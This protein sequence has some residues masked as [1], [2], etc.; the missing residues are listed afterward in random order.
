MTDFTSVAAGNW[1]TPATWD[2]GSGYPDGLDDKA[3]I[4]GYA[5][6]IAAGD[7]DIAGEVDIISGQLTVGSGSSLE[8]GNSVTP[9]LSVDGSSTLVRYGRIKGQDSGALSRIQFATGATDSVPAS[10]HTLRRIL[11]VTVPDMDASD[12]L[13]ATTEADQ[14]T[15]QLEA[16]DGGTLSIDEDIATGGLIAE[17]D[18]ILSFDAGVD[19]AFVSG[20]NLSNPDGIIQVNGTPGSPV[21]FSA[22][23]AGTTWNWYLRPHASSYFN[24][25]TVED[26][27]GAMLYDA[28]ST[29]GFAFAKQPQEV[30]PL[31]NPP[32]LDIDDP[33]GR[34]YS[35]VHAKG[36]MA[37][38]IEIVGN[39]RYSDGD[40]KRVD[41][42]MKNRVLVAFV[43]AKMQVPQAYV[44]LNDYKFREGHL[45]TPYTIT[46]QEA[47]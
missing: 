32:I 24:F 19:V 12:I 6:A 47:R 38:L 11:Y 35:R 34:D 43:N 30:D 1:R 2:V 21:T 5:V 16:Y 44:V 20:G 15:V 23:T 13:G 27:S 9:A 40:H 33:F 36:G 42:M 37:A 14:L 18:G 31:Q 46:L 29:Y 26:L 39:Y 25:L 7:D 3:I 8:L 10:S 45:T 17:D 22:Y 28:D 4:S 41:A